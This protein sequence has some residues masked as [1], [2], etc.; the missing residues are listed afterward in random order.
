MQV[1]TLVTLHQRYCHDG[2]YASTQVVTSVTLHT[3]IMD[4]VQARHGAER[5]C[6]CCSSVSCSSAP[7]LTPTASSYSHYFQARLKPMPALACAL[8]CLSSSSG[9]LAWSAQ[10]N[11]LLFM[12]SCVHLN[13]SDYCAVV[14]HTYTSTR[15]VLCA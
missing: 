14:F 10:L 1:S 12:L 6:K 15:L 8:L 7:P 3:L 11:E 2:C 9:L 5:L 13:S 4:A